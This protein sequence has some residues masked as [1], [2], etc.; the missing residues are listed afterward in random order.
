MNPGMV[1]KIKKMQKEMLKAQ[2]ELEQSTFYGSAGGK[3][4]TVEF[5]GDK[6]MRD[7][8]IKKEALES[9]DD[10]DILQ[11]TVIAAIN[12][13]MKKIDEETESVM[14]EFTGGMP[15]MF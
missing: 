6:K 9:L 1:N 15:G 4:V 3:M 5:T 11:D 2:K 12:D 8:K 14:G 13:C 7:I 10:L